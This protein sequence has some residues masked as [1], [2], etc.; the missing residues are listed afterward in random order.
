LFSPI[1]GAS[2]TSN[3]GRPA[4]A[5]IG[6]QDAPLI[7]VLDPSGAESL[8]MNGSVTMDVEA[9]TVQID[10]N[11]RCAFDASGAAGQMQA[12]RT[13]VVGG[14]CISPSN[15]TGDLITQSFYVPDPLA[16]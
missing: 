5:V 16:S 8:D 11:A 7:L 9:G 15:L 12:Q 6:P 14:A 2:G 1:L 4:T 3:V 10:S 13:R